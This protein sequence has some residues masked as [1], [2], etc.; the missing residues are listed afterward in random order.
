MNTNPAE[1]EDDPG[2]KYG[3]TAKS[4]LCDSLELNLGLRI[5]ENGISFNP[6]G[7]G[8]DFSVSG[9]LVRGSRLDVTRTGKG[10]K[11]NYIFNGSP[12][13]TGFLAWKMLRRKHNRLQIKMT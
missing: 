8:R 1:Y 2:S 12:L 6:V 3:L 10:R 5:N 7:N 11:A 9:L 4:W 13:K